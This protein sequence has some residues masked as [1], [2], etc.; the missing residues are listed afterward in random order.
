MNKYIIPAVIALVVSGAVGLFSVGSNQSN[1]DLG[2]L[3]Q[4]DVQ[5]VSLKVGS[6]TSKFNVNSSGTKVG[7]GTTTPAAGG[8]VVVDGSATTTLMLRSSTRGSCIEM[9]TITGSTVR[10]TVSGTTISAVAGSCR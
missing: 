7:V 10:I 4:R 6:P 8:D 5:A 9:Q 2:S 1:I 3:S